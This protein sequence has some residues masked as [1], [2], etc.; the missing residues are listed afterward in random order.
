MPSSIPSALNELPATLDETYER[1]LQGIPK[2]KWQHAHRLFQ[3][4]VAAVRPLRVVELSEIFAIDF[5]QGASPN[6]MEGWRPE[7]PEEAILS[8]CS[9]LIAVV[10]EK[11][12]KIVQFSHFS[13]KEF[14]ISDRLQTSGN[15][16]YFHIPLDTAHT[17]LARACLI[18]LLQLD[19]AI[20]EGHVTTFPLTFYAA[21]HWVAHAKFGDVASRVRNAIERLFDPGKPYLTAWVR[22]C[23]RFG[24]Y[25]GISGFFLNSWRSPRSTALDLAVLSGFSWLVEHLILEHAAYVGDKTLLR[26]ALH[27]GYIDTMRVLLSH[28]ARVNS[29]DLH[30]KPLLKEAYDSLDLDAM[31]LLLEHGAKGDIPYASFGLLSHHASSHGQAD[32]VSMLLLHNVNVNAKGGSG[33]TP[34][35]WASSNGHAKVVKLLLDYGASIDAQSTAH[36]TPLSLASD[37]GHSEVVRLLLEHGADVRVL[38][39][40]YQ[41]LVQ[42]ATSRGD[43]EVAHE[44]LEQGA[45]RE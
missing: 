33:W 8:T 35:H 2:E 43:V 40:N 28:G 6:F 7:N 19:E 42:V 1:A 3:C 39:A 34:L 21:Q 32:V 5:G 18:V 26:N 11:G 10:E 25:S 24:I 4:L 30:N 45:E 29:H 44:S 15:T 16:S 37:S 27:R 36:Y 12:S 14:L 9:S 20:V 31:Q 13:V 22:I 38:G 23:D 17:I 41:T